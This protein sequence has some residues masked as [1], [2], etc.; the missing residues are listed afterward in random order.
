MG[1]GRCPRYQVSLLWAQSYSALSSHFDLERGLP[2]S[3]C[4]QASGFGDRG[5]SHMTGNTLTC[6]VSP[7]S[8]SW[9]LWNLL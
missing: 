6:A 8:Y 7:L 3:S 4:P 1:Q 9:L 5:L 2:W